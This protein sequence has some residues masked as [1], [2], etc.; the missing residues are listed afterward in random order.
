MFEK[1]LASNFFTEEGKLIPDMEYFKVLE[2]NSSPILSSVEDYWFNKMKV[3]NNLISIAEKDAFSH[4]DLFGLDGEPVIIEEVYKKLVGKKQSG[5]KLQ[6]IEVLW[7]QK[8]GSV[9]KEKADEYL[10][11][12]LNIDKGLL[13]QFIILDISLISWKSSLPH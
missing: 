4:K 9:D 1:D 13:E 5:K 11:K 3:Y 2:K 8:V 6:P 7:L 10:E 12:V